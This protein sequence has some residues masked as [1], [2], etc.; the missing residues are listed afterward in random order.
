VLRALAGVEA[1]IEAGYDL[2]ISPWL[3]ICTFFLAVFLAFS[4]RR[5]EV[6]SLGEDARGHRKNL[7]HY[8]P[9]LLDQMI[10]IATATSLM[11]YSIYTVSDRT[12]NEV[13]DMLWITIPFVAYG[14]FRYQYLVHTRGM[15][16]TPDRVLLRD[17]PL[18]AN[19]ALWVAAVV[20]VLAVFPAG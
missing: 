18:L 13:S 3:V 15:G 16:G 20:V 6:V 11:G 5:A 10:S 8:S 1:G 17:M 9:K 19:V 12:A 7:A 2:S 4:K 14:I